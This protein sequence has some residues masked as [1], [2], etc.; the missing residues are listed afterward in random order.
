MQKFIVLLLIS[1]VLLQENHP[2]MTMRDIACFYSYTLHLKHIQSV[3]KI[4]EITFIL[5]RALCSVPRTF[6]LKIVY[7]DRR[8]IGEKA[9]TK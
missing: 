3:S 4:P 1:N 9:G 7:N 5:Q 8:A 2:L 6:N